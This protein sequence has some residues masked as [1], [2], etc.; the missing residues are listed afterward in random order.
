MSAMLGAT[1]T[2][3]DAGVNKGAGVFV[4]SFYLPRIK[5]QATE[6][7]LLRVS[8]ICTL[9]FGAIIILVA[10]EFS[11]LRTKNLFDLV[12][13]LSA[14]LSAPLAIPLV[15]GLLYKRTPSW[16][17]WSTA[18]VGFLCS[19]LVN[20][21]A[22]PEMF[23]RLLGYAN[24]LSKSENTDMML[25]TTVILTF[26]ASILWFFGTTF[27]YRKDTAASHQRIE[28]FFKNLATPVVED[29]DRENRYEH[30]IY[31]VLGRLCS[32]YGGFVLFLMLIPN[33]LVGRLCFAFCGGVILCAGMVLLAMDRS[34]RAEFGALQEMNAA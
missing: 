34:K 10:V 28:S 12:N 7:E 16:S 19:S 11:V 24:P 21:F 17:A 18:L 20:G 29:P 33:S 30:G 4:R 23:Q 26:S 22:K 8:K 1:L 9:M 3:M 15:L 32:I 27:F 31:A 25:G 13:Q 5:P 2:S 14:S 6:K